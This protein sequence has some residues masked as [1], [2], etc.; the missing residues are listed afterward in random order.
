VFTE[1]LLDRDARG[2]QVYAQL[3]VNSAGALLSPTPRSPR[4]AP[5]GYEHPERDEFVP[6]LGSLD[7]LR[8]AFFAHSQDIEVLGFDVRD[9]ALEPLPQAVIDDVNDKLAASM[10]NKDEGSARQALHG[11]GG[12]YSIVAIELEGPSFESVWVARLGRV[13]A[14][15]IAGVTDM[16]RPVWSALGLR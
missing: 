16:L 4:D 13:E 7:L 9:R 10:R 1:A 11:P 6:K 8:L 14:P 15:S 12:P 3:L 2:G 5:G